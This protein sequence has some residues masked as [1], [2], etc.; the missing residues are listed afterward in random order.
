MFSKDLGIL[1]L[2]VSPDITAKPME[3]QAKSIMI[4]IYHH[5]IYSMIMFSHASVLNYAEVRCATKAYGSLVVCLCVC[6][7]S[8]DSS[9]PDGIQ[10]KLNASMYLK[11]HSLG[12]KLTKILR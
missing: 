6:V 11:P 5:D 2:A 7:C 1:F 4:I 8:R 3:L 10:V 9:S 12:F